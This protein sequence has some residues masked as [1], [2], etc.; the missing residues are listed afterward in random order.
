M[1]PLSIVRTLGVL[2]VVLGLLAV[3]LWLVRRYDLRL[4]GRV[5]DR[6]DDRRLGIV[7]RLAIDARRSLILVRRDGED[8][9]VLIG[10]DHALAIGAPSRPV[11]TQAGE[12]A[13]TTDGEKTREEKTA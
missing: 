11:A 12:L 10:P 1:E 8:H 5:A 3:A 2:L 13:K 9:L 4:P 7:E 6:R